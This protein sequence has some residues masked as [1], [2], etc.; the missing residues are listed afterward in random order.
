LIR[1][2][3]YRHTQR[4][5]VILVLCAATVLFSAAFA[6]VI[7]QRAAPGAELGALVGPIVIL[8]ALTGAAWYF[9]TMTVE[10]TDTELRWQLGLG[11]SRIDRSAIE[12]AAIV[13]HPWWHGYGIRWL[14][15]NCWTY[16]VSGN[17]TV[18]VRL[19]GGGWRRLGTDDPQGL[20]AALT[21]G[22][23]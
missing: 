18:E 9:S 5:T 23:R 2:M 20:L 4:G 12:S 15:P 10:V 17:E 1:S 11:V 22:R 14:G 13:R 6:V 21:S 7:W 8:I 19:K 3:L 16:I